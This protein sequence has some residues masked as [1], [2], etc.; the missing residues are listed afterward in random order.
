MADE[1]LYGPDNEEYNVTM[2][3]SDAPPPHISE[4]DM[5]KLNAEDT[6]ERRRSRGGNFEA[7]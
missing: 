1:G 7:S 2:V 4:H 6:D 3:P 5:E